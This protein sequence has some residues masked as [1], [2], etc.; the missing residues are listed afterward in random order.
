MK[1]SA[2][3]AVLLLPVLLVSLMSSPA[4]AKT[5]VYVSCAEDGEIAMLEMNLDTGDLKL[6]GKAK[7]GKIVMPMAVSPD[8]RFLYATLRS[9]PFAVVSYSIDSAK[10][11]LT[12]LSI[13][14]LPDN[15]AYISTDKT[16]R[17]LFSASYA[18]HKISVNPIGARGLVQA[19]P[20]QVLI[21]GRNAHSILSDPSNRFVYVPTLG[22]DQVM[23]FLFDEKTGFLTPNKP[24]AVYTKVGAGP[25]HLEF[26]PNNRF[27]YVLNELN[28]MVNAYAA[29]TQTGVLAEI[30]SI[31]AVPPDANLVP[32]IPAPPLGGAHPAPRPDRKEIKCA[33]IHISP[34]GRFLYA[35]ER[36]TSTLAAFAV[37][38][39]NGK[40]TY[41]KSYETETQPRG[42]NIDPR[43]NFVI[44]AGQKTGQL[45]VHR[46][47]RTTGE[48]QRLNRYP[49]GKDPNWIEVVDFP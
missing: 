9:V 43:G 27:V 33:D 46:I 23:Q 1:G 31:S 11:D 13:A 47:N 3:F 41:L 24:G 42:F 5:F 28:G 18:G 36:T 48:L 6:I 29:D 30:Q 44:A 19:D 7:A 34:D 45:S 22:N 21:T 32:G 39:G 26:S 20:V 12:Q 49:V 10:G 8:R 16:G 35:S 17:F 15:M 2:A 40:L 38:S 25:R 14:P 37:D 4:A